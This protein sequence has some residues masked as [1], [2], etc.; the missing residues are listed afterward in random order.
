MQN[1]KSHV[2]KP[3]SLTPEQIKISVSFLNRSFRETAET[4]KSRTGLTS[5]VRGSV[6]YDYQVEFAHLIDEIQRG[7]VF[8]AVQRIA[9]ANELISTMANYRKPIEENITLSK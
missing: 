9:E 2:E 4:F 1:K 5:N 6:L 8:C 7:P 3:M